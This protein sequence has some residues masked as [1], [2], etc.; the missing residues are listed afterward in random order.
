M[1]AYMT[2]ADGERNG[3]QRLVLLVSTVLNLNLVK[4][5]QKWDKGRVT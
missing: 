2:Q 1:T 3:E 4:H 5:W